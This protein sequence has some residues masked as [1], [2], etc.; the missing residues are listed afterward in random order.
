LLNKYKY[1]IDHGTLNSA[2]MIDEQTFKG[3]LQMDEKTVRS[4]A[5]SL[6]GEPNV[7]I[8]INAAWLEFK[9]VSKNM[10]QVKAAFEKMISS[11]EDMLSTWTEEGE[12]SENL[13]RVNDLISES[14]KDLKTM[15]EA[16]AKHK[17]CKANESDLGAKIQTVKSLMEL[18][19]MHSEAWKK[20]KVA[21]VS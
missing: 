8:E 18:A 3:D 19:N 7:K 13:A 4:T 14:Q 21:F 10:L 5:K 12:N 11:A 20:M 6:A 16:I 1:V 2:S 9:S 15:R 17:G